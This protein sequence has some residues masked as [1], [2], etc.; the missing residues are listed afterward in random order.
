MV[1]N[2]K[3]CKV[4]III[5]LFI[6]TIVTVD[7][8]VVVG[9]GGDPKYCFCA[10]SSFRNLIQYSNKKTLQPVFFLLLFSLSLSD[11]VRISTVD[12]FH[13]LMIDMMRWCCG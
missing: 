5:F 13:R 6:V 2:G 7:V 4:I 8:V 10:E 9:G 1:S 11:N 3:Y 12:L